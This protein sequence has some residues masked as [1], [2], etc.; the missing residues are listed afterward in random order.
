[1][2]IIAI[3]G[4]GRYPVQPVHIDDLV[5]ICVHA[6]QG[7]GNVALDAAGHLFVAEFSDNS[8]TEYGAGSSGNAMPIATISGSSTGLTAP[9][10]LGI[11]AAGDTFVTNFGVNTVTAP[12]FELRRIIPLSSIDLLRK[13]QHRFAR[14]LRPGR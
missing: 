7:N 13:C 11:D 5:Q 10:G 14:K 4:N 9:Y 12:R 6:A 1:M 2:P 3:P 8:V